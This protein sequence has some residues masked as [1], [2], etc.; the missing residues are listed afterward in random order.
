ME[1]SPLRESLGAEVGAEIESSNGMS[2]RN[3]D[4]KLEEYPLGE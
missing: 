3:G 2:Y 4:G 1:G